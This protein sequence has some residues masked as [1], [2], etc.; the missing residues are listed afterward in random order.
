MENLPPAIGHRRWVIGD[1]YIP[2]W[3]NG[4][5]PELLSHESA[6]ILNASEEAAHVRITVFFEDRDPVAY[7][8]TVPGRRTK[9]QRFNDLRD[10]EMPLG[11]GYSAVVEADVP[12][13][14]QHTRL[15]SRQSACALLSTVAY[16][17]ARS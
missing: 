16:P 10:P 11:L 5:E 8:L 15:D 9:H 17:D 4:P 6:S 3:S 2:S 13:V 7:E 14:V 1:G 12:I